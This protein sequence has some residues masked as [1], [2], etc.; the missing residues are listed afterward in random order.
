MNFELKPF[1]LLEAS[2]EKCDALVVLVPQDFKA[3]KDDLSEL[4]GQ[5]MKAGDLETKT[6]KLLCLYKPV[7]AH[8]IR[9]VLVGIG[10]GSARDVRSAVLAAMASV[11]ALD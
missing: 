10:S 4:I 6:A 2:T 3:A 1:S 5:A 11:K 8:A 7:Q 9:V